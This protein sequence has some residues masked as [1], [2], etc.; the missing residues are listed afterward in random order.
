MKN[1]DRKN[2]F[3]AVSLGL[4]LG[5]LIAIPIVVFL[6]L[7]VFLDK[8]LDTFP[9]LMIAS[10]FLGLIATAFDVYYLVLPFLKKKVENNKN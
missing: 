6:A 2:L 5:F 3:Y 4:E 9:Y 1:G 10:I 8:T 7:G